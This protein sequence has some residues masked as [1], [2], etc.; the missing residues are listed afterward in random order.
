MLFLQYLFFLTLFPIEISIT[1]LKS[2]HMTK[3]GP[4]LK[5]KTV[6]ETG[7]CTDHFSTMQKNTNLQCPVKN[8]PSRRPLGFLSAGPPKGLHSP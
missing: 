3:N 1:P 5:T 4:I 7:E 6:L 8:Q 2:G